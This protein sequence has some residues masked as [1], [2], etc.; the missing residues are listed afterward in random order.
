MSSGGVKMGGLVVVVVVVGGDGGG[1]G[2][3]VRG[4][5][6]TSRLSLWRWTGRIGVDVGVAGIAVGDVVVLVSSR[7]YIQNDYNCNTGRRYLVQ[8]R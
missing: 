4:G 6:R 5:C 1:Y 8:P 2:V 3:N 7:R